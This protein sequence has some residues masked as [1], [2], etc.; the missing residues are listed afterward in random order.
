MRS[1]DELRGAGSWQPWKG[2]RFQAEDTE[3]PWEGF[4][5]GMALLDLHF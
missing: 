2:T 5:Q 1:E 3:K 4:R